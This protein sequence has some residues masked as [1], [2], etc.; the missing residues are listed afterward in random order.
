M[1][2]GFIGLSPSDTPFA[3]LRLCH[4]PLRGRILISYAIAQPLKGEG[5]GFT[6]LIYRAWLAW[7]PF[8]LSFLTFHQIDLPPAQ[9]EQ[10]LFWA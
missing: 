4:L 3:S 1:G 10:R 9:A 8:A 6:P 5:A 7:R 2:A